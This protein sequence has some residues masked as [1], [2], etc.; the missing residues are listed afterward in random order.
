VPVSAQIL[1]TCALPPTDTA[2]DPGL[3]DPPP[4]T[5]ETGGV[6]SQILWELAQR[7][8]L[9]GETAAQVCDRYGL[10]VSTL[11][12]RAR[13]GE[14]RKSD[15]PDPLLDD[16]DDP[17]DA[18]PVDC[19]ALADDAL[20]RVR[21]ALNRG[22]A[23]EAASWM[24]LHE[25]LVRRLDEVVEIERRSRRVDG[26]RRSF[27]ALDRLKE[28]IQLAS[29][30]VAVEQALASDDLSDEMR[31][32]LSSQNLAAAEAVADFIEEYPHPPHSNFSESDAGGWGD[33][34]GP[35]EPDP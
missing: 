3:D 31:S 34:D 14:W 32:A 4:D 11:R 16:E 1:E 23:V 35:D 10:N 24:R 2:A 20:K 28:A 19:Q 17:E 29:G 21:R 7:D 18:A 5:P 22:R 12:D 26:Q 30:Q 8:Y 6:R 15:Q 25:K 33:P 9:R 27:P 13:K